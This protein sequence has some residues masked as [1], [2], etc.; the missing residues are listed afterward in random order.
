MRNI[1]ESYV[2]EIAKKIPGVEARPATNEEDCGNRKAD[3]VIKYHGQE[4]FIQVSHQPKSKRERRK[5][6]KRGTYP[7]H[8]HKYVGHPLE[9][10]EIRKE[11][12]KIIMR[13]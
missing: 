3:I 9:E 8:T 11:I 4:Y 10:Y 6:I 2:L 1:D 7:V 5:L 13:S 12:E